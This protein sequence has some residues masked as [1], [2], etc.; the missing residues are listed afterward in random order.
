MTPIQLLLTNKHR[1]RTTLELVSECLGFES[2]RKEMK[3]LEAAR[4]PMVKHAKTLRK[5]HRSIYMLYQG[6][7]QIVGEVK[8]VN[9]EVV[10]G[11][12]PPWETSCA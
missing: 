4:L 1:G 6:P 11:W 2:A 9:E 12:T 8:K 7:D 10:P 5:A 3:R